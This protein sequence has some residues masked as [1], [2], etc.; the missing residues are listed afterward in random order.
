MKL[1][2]RSDL[3][4]VVEL[5]SREVHLGLDTE[6]TGLSFN[7]YPFL[8]IIATTNQTYLFN[9][10][11]YTDLESEF[12][13][14]DEEI[15]QLGPVLSDPNK[16]FFIHNAKFDMG[17]VRKKGL[18]IENAWCTYAQERVI[19]NNY[20]SYSLD[21][22][23]KR[24][25]LG[26]GK[27]NAVEEYIQKNK[28]YT[29]ENIPGKKK[30]EKRKHFEK[31]PYQV[32]FPYA[33]NDA[34]LHLEVGLR[35]MNELENIPKVEGVPHVARVSENELYITKVCHE[36]EYQG[37]L[38]DKQYTAKAMLYEMEKLE[39]AK[40]QFVGYHG[41]PFIDSGVFLA[42]V[43]T[44]EGVSF[45]K[46][47]KGNPSFTAENLEKI[48]H[49]TA[50]LVEKIREHEKMIGTY[51]S[52]FLFGC[53]KEGR[54]HPNMNQ[55]G[56]ETGRFSYSNPNLQNVPKQ[57]EEGLPYYVRKCF[58][59]TPGYTFVMIDYQQ[60]EFRMMID[61]A[62]EHRLIKAINDGAD[63]H[64]ATADLIG[65]SRSRAKTINFGLLYGM[66]IEKLAKDLGVSVKQAREIKLEYFSKLPHVERFIK[67]VVRTGSSRGYIYNWF[68]RRNYIDDKNFAYILP[69]HLIQGG[70]ADVIK[71][72]MREIH[73]ILKPYKSRMVLQVHDE[74]IF[75]IKY[76]E[77]FLVE[78]IK[79]VM[80]RIYK[81]KNGMKLT[82]SVEHSRVSWGQPDRIKG[83]PLCM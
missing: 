21:S 59:P 83:A 8:I 82:C 48:S 42:K 24:R 72:A 64:Q 69:N 20:L 23:A 27:S 32:M 33:A 40:A 34:E 38:I 61:Y 80:E 66:G 55:G 57:E 81:P 10:N 54:I 71:L 28:L 75:E 76:G 35:Q 30:R 4:S 22:I 45:P 36:M 50:R 41:T 26:V 43:F 74:L 68:G 77:E 39:E 60:Q 5:L 53:D 47:A 51:Y 62:G 18:I 56:T 73:G 49:P 46:T 29:V 25:N 2:G 52:S 11:P 79:E 19:K 9:Q 13:L 37:V 63:V 78:P 16:L 44:N 1:V 15:K 7:D 67:S 12:I 6:T 3:K 17:M 70:G 65:V 14:T 58:I 31:V